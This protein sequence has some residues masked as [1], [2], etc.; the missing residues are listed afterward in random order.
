M[1]ALY[2]ARITCLS[3]S[4][5]HFENDFAVSILLVQG[6]SRWII[7]S[8]ERRM[9]SGE[10]SSSLYCSRWAYPVMTLKRSVTS[11][12]IIRSWQ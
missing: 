10:T 2:R 3:T 1:E 8:R 11:A 12:Q 9:D 4:W 6:V 7:S 5:L